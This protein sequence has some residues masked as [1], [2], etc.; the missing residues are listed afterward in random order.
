MNWRHA[1]FYGLFGF[2]I[3]HLAG[4]RLGAR[5]DA[6][7]V[8]DAYKRGWSAAVDA[9]EICVTTVAGEG[10]LGATNDG[11][12]TWHCPERIVNVA[13][14]CVCDPPE[15]VQIV[16][17]DDKGMA[18]FEIPY[19]EAPGCVWRGDEHLEI[20]PA[21]VALD[22]AFVRLADAGSLLGT[23]VICYGHRE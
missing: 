19:T 3:G 12:G 6:Q 11:E 5:Q 21:G 1:I 13:P 15:L 4:N 9:G 22:T 10:V 23:N 7:G 14:E 18:D 20:T 17:L 8:V 2:A 16:C